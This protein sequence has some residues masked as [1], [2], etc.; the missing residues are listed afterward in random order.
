MVTEI[1]KFMTGKME[2]NKEAPNNV[3][4]QDTNKDGSPRYYTYGTTFFNYGMIP[5]T[6]EDPELRTSAG[7]GGDNDPLDIIEFGSV[8]LAMGS[9]TPCCII[10]WFL[11]TD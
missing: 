3:I 8:P 4:Q 6:W 9:I 11:G 10:G 7:H 5:Q 2:V 1:P